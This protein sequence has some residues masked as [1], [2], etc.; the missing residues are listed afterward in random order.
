MFTAR[1]FGGTPAMSLPGSV[2]PL[3]SLGSSNPAKHP[4]HRGLAAARRPKQ[5]K[6]FLLKDIKR[7]IVDRHKFAKAFGD[8]F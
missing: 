3:P 2:D 5:R 8:V 1:W 4:H 6:E 7:E